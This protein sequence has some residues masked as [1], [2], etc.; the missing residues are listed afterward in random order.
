[1]AEILGF[2]WGGW[3]KGG[4]G[5]AQ[6]RRVEGR[7]HAIRFLWCG[8]QQPFS[9][10]LSGRLRRRHGDQAMTAKEVASR[11]RTCPLCEAMCGLTLEVSAYRVLGVR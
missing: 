4:T 10:A 3:R 7:G 2:P 5:R 11:R 8:V 6:G 9:G 1:M